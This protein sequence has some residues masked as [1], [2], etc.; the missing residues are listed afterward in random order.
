[1]NEAPMQNRLPQ[2]KLDFIISHFQTNLGVN[3]VTILCKLLSYISLNFHYHHG[4]TKK[5]YNR[6]LSFEEK[7]LY[8]ELYSKYYIEKYDK[9]VESKELVQILDKL[10]ERLKY[11]Q[12]EVLR[13]VANSGIESLKIG[14]IIEEID[15]DIKSK[16]NQGNV[17]RLFNYLKSNTI[18]VEE[19]NKKKMEMQIKKEKTNNLLEA[20]LK[21]DFVELRE[22]NQYQELGHQY[23][24]Y[25][26]TFRITHTKFTISEE[27]ISNLM[28]F[29][30][31]EFVLQA[32]I[33]NKWKLINI[34]LDEISANQY[35]TQN[36]YFTKLI[37]STTIDNVEGKDQKLIETNLKNSITRHLDNSIFSRPGAL[38]IQ[39]EINPELEK[40]NYSLKLLNK[41][42]ILVTLNHYAIQFTLNKFMNAIQNEFKMSDVKKIAKKEVALLIDEGYNLANQVIKGEYQHMNMEVDIVFHGPKFILPHNINDP[43]NS[44]CIMI[45]LGLIETTSYLAPLKIDN[46]DYKTTKDII[47]IYDEYKTQMTGF[48]LSTVED[49]FAFR[50]ENSEKSVLK[51]IQNVNVKIDFSNSNQPKNENF[52]NIRMKLF[53]EDFIINLRDKQ[54]EFIIL[55]YSNFLTISANLTKELE[56][57]KKEQKSEKTDL[58]QF[59]KNQEKSTFMKAYQKTASIFFF[60]LAVIFKKDKNFLIVEFILT[61]FEFNIIKSLSEEEIQLREKNN[62]SNQIKFKEFLNFTTN[63]IK[64]SFSYSEK[65]NIN[66]EAN[67]SGFSFYD[68]DNVLILNDF[69]EEDKSF[70]VNKEFRVKIIFKLAYNGII[71]GRYKYK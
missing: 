33:G 59:T 4:I 45:N 34:Y 26:I 8:V 43:K 60:K 42:K 27:K 16:S 21:K 55:F 47:L 19:L 18:S 14:K 12:I 13:R 44:G 5:F 25:D 63:Y 9:K 46:I 28:I 58:S 32:R 61:K 1:M 51:L 50:N 67:I 52:E 54:I 15:T 7:K 64:Y 53:V 10:E 36:K 66:F 38:N 56:N 2:I 35:K 17:G 11:E 62:L 22:E 31:K 48:E 41:K 39:F 40:S 71:K 23:M 69:L 30:F 68:N 24:V 57:I 20:E 37:E 70:L 49:Y 6:N 3:H 65:G 29:Y